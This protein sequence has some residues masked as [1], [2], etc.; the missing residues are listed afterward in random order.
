VAEPRLLT[1]RLREVFRPCLGRNSGPPPD[2]RPDGPALA[3]ALPAAAFSADQPT[4]SQATVA[5][6]YAFPAALNQ[7]TTVTSV[8]PACTG[9]A[10]E[11]ISLAVDRAIRPV[12]GPHHKVVADDS[13][14]RR[15]PTSPI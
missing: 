4:T 6:W 2:A 9:L 3:T 1:G 13:P 8:P 10:H 14:T 11:Q 12:V 15:P 5:T 7:H